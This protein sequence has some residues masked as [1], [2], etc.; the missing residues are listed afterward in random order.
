MDPVTANLL[1]TV[2]LEAIKILG[3]AIVAAYVG[4]KAASV[5]IKMKLEE[6]RQSH[7]FQARQALFEELRTRIARAD[8]E[9]EKANR[10]LGEMI[11]MAAGFH[12]D[13]VDDVTSPVLTLWGETAVSLSRTVRMDVRATLRDM[14][15]CALTESDEYEA[16]DAW[17]D[18]LLALPDFRH[19]SVRKALLELREVFD[20]VSR[21]SREV[22]HKRLDAAFEPYLK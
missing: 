18:R 13:D 4:Y 17:R 15:A 10:E 7:R 21:G 3:P 11:G 22:L 20:L 8:L 2:S 12:H 1:E 5:Q 16:L 6:L 19:S 14:E 9:E